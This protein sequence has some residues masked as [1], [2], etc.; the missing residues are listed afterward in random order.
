VPV[1]VGNPEIPA[2]VK[3]A[4]A[5][6]AQPFAHVKLTWAPP[7]QTLFVVVERRADGEKLWAVIAGPL[8]GFEVDDSHPPLSGRIE[9]RI[10]FQTAAGA[11]GPA[12]AAVAITR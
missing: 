9:Y 1:R 7:P 3:P 5:F 11:T 6:A 10:H 4:A 8:S 12:S 2:P